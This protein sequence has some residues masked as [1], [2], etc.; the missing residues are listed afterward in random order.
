MLRASNFFLIISTY[1]FSLHKNNILTIIKK[2]KTILTV[3]SFIYNNLHPNYFR[4]MHI[5]QLIYVQ[6]AYFEISATWS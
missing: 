6:L 2:Q 3:F 5:T 1:Y 4:Y